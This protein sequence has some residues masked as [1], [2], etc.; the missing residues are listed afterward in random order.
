MEFR[1]LGPLEVLASGE[2]LDVGGLRQR[3][4]LALLL[5]DAG[6]V[7]TVDRLTDAI[8]GEVLPPT[9]KAQVQICISALR[10][11]FAAH[12]RPT[13][14]VTHPR[15]YILEAEDGDELDVRRFEALTAQARRDR[16][17]GDPESAVRGYRE[18]LALWRG[19]AMEG[20]E[21][22]PVRSAASR[23]AEHRIT[24]NEDCLQL[25]LDLGR[26]HELVGELT[27]LVAEHPLRERLRGQLMLALYRSGRQADALRVYRLARET[28]VEELGIEPNE[29]LQRLE[30]AILTSDES[31]NGP[32]RVTIPVEP[33]EPP[34]ARPVPI[35][36]PAAVADFT[37]RTK[38]ID[39]IQRELALAA[40]DR[41]RLAVPIIVIAGQG[42]LGKTTLAVHAAHTIADRYPDGQLFTD[43]HGGAYRQISAMQVLERFLRALGVAGTDM[44]D[45]LEERAEM[46]RALL[47]DRRTLIVLDDAARESQVM[48]LLPGNRTSA[49]IITSRS[50]LTGLPGAIQIEMDIFDSDQSLELLGR[51][52]G[53]DRVRAEPGEAVALSE[54]C[55]RLPLALRIAGARLSAR[56]H[57]SIEQLVTR[58]EDE[59]RR[60]D[61]LKHGD[62]GIRASISL[63]YESVGADARRLFRLLAI[64]DTSVFSAWLA[65]A[66]LG[67]SHTDAQDLLDELADA[68]LIGPAGPGFGVHSQ[69]RFHDLVRVFAR[70]R[71][72]AEENAAERKTALERALGA[73]LYVAE[74]AH[75]RVYGEEYLQVHSSAQR[76]PLPAKLVDKLVAD[77]MVWYERERPLLVSGIRQAARAGFAELCWDLAISAV[78]LF[79]S[80][81]YL[82]DWRETHEVALAAT[83]HV[84]DPR[85]Q[86]AILYSRGSLHIT[87][88]R[89]AEAR[90]DFEEAIELF[91]QV[92]DDLGVALVLRNVAFLDRMSGLTDEAAARYSHALDIFTRTGDQVGAAYVLHNLAQLRLDDGDPEG[93]SRLLAEALALSRRGGSRRVEAQVLHRMGDTYLQWDEPTLAAEIF[94]TAI[95][96]VRE[97]GDPI[98]E[99]YVLCG[100]GVARLRLGEAAEADEALRL[101]VR[102]GRSAGDGFAEG[103]ALLGLGELALSCDDN[104]HAVAHLEQALTVF[105]TLGIPVYEAQAR[106]MLGRAEAATRPEGLTTVGGG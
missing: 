20:I 54:L 51:I 17:A 28:L 105:R 59:T 16:D 7:V 72:A 101:A 30:Y 103:R 1:I 9:S 73:L 46:Y 97:I 91:N 79:E 43:L 71:L 4:T 63:T 6:R 100:L 64:L 49:V 93:A 26:H 42:G 84:G 60:L 88:K 102:L 45:G 32:A 24:T 41:Y 92:G 75:R 52:A 57:W 15:G 86:A 47:A 48:P 34:P 74:A 2:R 78:T 70:E 5:L 3:I 38:Q 65:G 35:L 77:P 12:G 31:L 104:A 13:L 33:P 68:Q 18:A 76:R 89:L 39:A 53:N 40:E 37:G 11:L 56:P 95:D 23:L 8:Y 29:Q 62:M 83:R 36:L 58:L 25:E 55:G 21:S 87:L 90:R 80:R 19:E 27:A 94:G 69:Y 106:A 81:I 85:G 98:G 10:R 22:R 61:E 44:P 82:D 67:G 14:I 66:L 96:I 99:A 50:R